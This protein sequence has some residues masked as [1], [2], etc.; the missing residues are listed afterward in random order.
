[1]DKDFSKLSESFDQIVNTRRSVR[2]YDN[3]IEFDSSVVQKSL[4]R[5][6]LAP[7][8]SNMQL[9]EFYRVKSEHKKAELA[10]YCLNQ[11]T[12]K[13]ANELIVIVTRADLWK[14]R[15]QF[16]IE[17]LKTAQTKDPKSIDP[18]V[19]DY[20]GKLIPTLYNNDSL[21]IAAF[22]KKIFVSIKGI[23]SPFYREVGR[24]DIR[25]MVHKSAALAAQTFM[26]SITAEGY[27]TCPMEG[28]DS[29][30]IK[31]MLDLPSGAEINMVI[32]VGKAK[33]EGIF[34]PRV[35]VEN[36]EVIYTI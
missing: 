7:N 3:T 6:V 11:S 36:S 13:T 34:G 21:G 27:D 26:L 28:F 29:K 2:I 18:R 30:R 23:S 19:F 25:V 31:K 9:W 5:A 14:K 20:Y 32:S 4:E 33:P 1:M 10:T 12:A 24:N 35:R 22:F 16:M 17:T 15:Q 8:S